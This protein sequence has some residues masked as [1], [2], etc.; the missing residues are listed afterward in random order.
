VRDTDDGDTNKKVRKELVKTFENDKEYADYK[1]RRLKEAKKS[2]CDL[3]Y[4]DFAR[5]TGYNITFFAPADREEYIRTIEEISRYV[6]YREIIMFMGK[7][8]RISK[9][10]RLIENAGKL[11]QIAGYPD[12]LSSVPPRHNF[13]IIDDEEVFVKGLA[14]SHPAIVKYYCRFYDEL[15]GS[16]TPIKVSAEENL[17][18]VKIAE[19]KAN[20]A[21]PQL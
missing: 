12:T 3:T 20:A 6:K 7:D 5:D 15:W 10:K 18:L 19:E 4:E 11:Y 17:E 2:V 21:R 1:S 9:I 13:I 8:A 16:A 14:I